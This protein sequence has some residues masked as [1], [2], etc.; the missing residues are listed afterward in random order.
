MN[1]QLDAE[2]TRCAHIFRFNY[3]NY[4]YP[5]IEHKLKY[6]ELDNLKPTR[7]LKWDDAHKTIEYYKYVKERVQKYG[8]HFGTTVFLKHANYRQ[9]IQEEEDKLTEYFLYE[10]RKNPVEPIDLPNMPRD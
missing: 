3:L 1:Y 8:L 5:L 10:M 7:M 6:G 9:K 4:V 2:I